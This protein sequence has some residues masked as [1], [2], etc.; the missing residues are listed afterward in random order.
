VSAKLLKVKIAKLFAKH[1]K[2]QEQIE[3][4]SAEYFPV[5]VGTP[6]RISKLIEMGAL[7]FRLAKVVLV[8]ITEDSKHY[9]ILSLHEVKHD[10]YKLLYA[11]VHAN[12][13]HLKIALINQTQKLAPGAAASS[14]A[15]SAGEK[16]VKKPFIAKKVRKEE[17]AAV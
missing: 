13:T 7:S 8:D 9:N 16:K 15:A 14:S 4:L 6:N 12:R 10:F 5:V 17:G 11:D 2:V 3:M 1:F